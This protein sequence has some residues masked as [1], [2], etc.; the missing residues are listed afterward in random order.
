MEREFKVPCLVSS[1]GPLG[2]LGV[3]ASDSLLESD[4]WSQA[5]DDI[6]SSSEVPISIRTCLT[7]P[8]LGHRMCGGGG[9]GGG[10]DVQPS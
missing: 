7:D 3:F 1:W 10:V 2:Y 5:M 6:K 8:V 9:G 4:R